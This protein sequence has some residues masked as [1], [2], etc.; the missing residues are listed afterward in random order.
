MAIYDPIAE[1]AAGLQG[2]FEPAS[3][4]L[5]GDGDQASDGDLVNTLTDLASTGNATA[6]GGDR[7][8]YRAAALNG[9][10]AIESTSQRVMKTAVAISAF[11][12]VN[13]FTV[14]AVARLFD[15]AHAGASGSDN[16]HL[17]GDD[18]GNLGLA[19][20]STPSVY[21]WNNDGSG[22]ATPVIATPDFLFGAWYVFVTVHLT[23]TLAQSLNLGSQSTVASGNTAS[24]ADVLVIGRNYAGASTGRYWHGQLAHLRLYDQGLSGPDLTERINDLLLKYGLGGNVPTSEQALTIGSSKLN[25]TRRGVMIPGVA[26]NMRDALDFGPGPDPIAL[27]HYSLPNS[28]I[29]QP[30]RLRCIVETRVYNPE[31]YEGDGPSSRLEL[32]DTAPAHAT[33]WDTGRVANPGETPAR[34]GVGQALTLNRGCPKYVD[35]PA[36]PSEILFIG[37]GAEAQALQ[38]HLLERGSTGNQQLRGSFIS[39][40]TG[41]AASSGDGVRSLDTVVVRFPLN[42]VPNSYRITM[43]GSVATLFRQALPA[44]AAYGGS[45]PVVITLDIYLVTG[46]MGHISVQRSGGG[47]SWYR[48]SD[49]TFQAT[50]QVITTASL[51]LLDATGGWRRYALK[52][53]V[54]GAQT[55]QVNLLGPLTTANQIWAY[56]HVQQEIGRWP[57][58]RM[59]TDDVVMPRDL[60]VFARANAASPLRS[61]PTGIFTELDVICPEWAYNDSSTYTFMLRCVVYDASN[62]VKVFFT[63]STGLWTLQVRV[64]GTSHNATAPGTHAAGDV[65][66]IGRRLTGGQGEL[67]LPAYTASIFVNGAK[68]AD[69]AC[70]AFPTASGSPALYIGNDGSA[71]AIDAGLRHNRLE[72]RCWS[73]AEIARFPG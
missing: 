48:D 34:L 28:G 42:L 3:G 73:D 27:S 63:A 62:W 15:N 40:F 68:G 71:N 6:S 5:N 43:N 33:H 13:A 19:S 50:E 39:G 70:G 57:S 53:F 20:K 45:D 11:L 17:W 31:A 36:S 12:N 9:H 16:Q 14:L 24:M 8:T 69:A 30:D 49:G 35:N 22:D 56:A 41:L 1:A 25:Q 23:G 21:A 51:R 65:V 55:V 2:W 59:L 37:V 10:D 61:F 60:D 26:V 58:S 44:S 29:E 47:S 67:G 64:A 66:T 38:G 32:R 7:W 4:A 18:G 72:A 52:A 46:Q 54:P